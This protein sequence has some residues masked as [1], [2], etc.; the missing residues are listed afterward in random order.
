[1]RGWL[2]Q[3]TPSSYVSLSSCRMT[4]LSHH[5]LLLHILFL[6]VL[7]IFIVLN[8]EYWL[9]ANFMMQSYKYS[10]KVST[11]P[12]LKQ[13][14]RL[15]QYCPYRRRWCRSVDVGLDAVS[16]PPLLF[17]LQITCFF[18]I[19]QTFRKLFLKNFTQSQ[20]ESANKFL[21]LRFLLCVWD[22]EFRG[23]KAKSPGAWAGRVSDFNSWA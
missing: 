21:R 23:G 2:L 17:H 12:L 20:K 18:L 13:S 4:L 19:L 5:D 1:M 16:L 22:L 6:V 15:V 11:N 10:T 14:K 8:V 9:F 7:I 3:P